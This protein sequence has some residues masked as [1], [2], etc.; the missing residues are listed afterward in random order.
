M[1]GSVCLTGP[2][3]NI[4]KDREQSLHEKERIQSRDLCYSECRNHLHMV[5]KKF[6][7]LTVNELYSL[8]KLRAEVFV[9]E[10]NCPYLDPDG[11]DEQSWHLFIMEEEQCLA[12]ARLLPPGTAYPEASIGRV[13]TAKDARNRG[14]GLLIMKEAISQSRQLFKAN[15]IHISA[16]SYLKK[17]YETFGFQQ[18]GEGYLEDDIPHLPMTLIFN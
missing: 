18:D 3:I 2:W 15:S 16:Q 10:Q 9:V 1:P 11:K 17:F 8:L 7:D 14:L 4:L 13:V 12:Y 5:L 6:E